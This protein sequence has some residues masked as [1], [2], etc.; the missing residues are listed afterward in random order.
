V[1][2]LTEIEDSAA[3]M[4]GKRT[5]Q[6]TLQMMTGRRTV[7]NVF[8]GGKSIG[9]GDETTMLHMSGELNDL[10]RKAGAFRG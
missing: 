1:F 10:L 4:T 3:K 8:V 2:D 7:P 5:I 9:G 6:E